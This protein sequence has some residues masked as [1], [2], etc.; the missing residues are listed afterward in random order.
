MTV[1]RRALLLIGLAALTGAPI[2]LAA[3]GSNR[4]VGNCDKSEVKP[5]SIILAC[6]DVNNYVNKI[7]W[8]AFGGPTASGS[9]TFVENTCTPSCV[10]GKFKDYPITFTLSQAKPCFDERNDYRLIAITFTSDR[11][12]KTP[13]HTK[14][15]LFCP[16]G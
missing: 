2:A 3:G 10:A 7:H 9:G 11:P 5:S 13:V 16:V 12:P 4:V 15:E 8:R 6:A 14:E 1:V